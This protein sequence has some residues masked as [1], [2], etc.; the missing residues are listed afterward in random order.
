MR[1]PGTLLRRPSPALV[2]AAL[3]LL[4]ALSGSGYAAIVLPKTSVGTIQLRPG[5]VTSPKVRDATLRLSDL[6]PAT[7]LALK[8]DPG[9][10]GAAGVSG[11]VIVGTSSTFDSSKSKTIVVR[12]PTGK[13]L[14]GGGAGAW[15][16][17]MVFVPDGVALT[18]NHP[19]DE[20]GWL[21]A[22]HEVVPTEQDWSLRANAVCAAVG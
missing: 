20:T 16:R 2:V 9:A 22:A 7:R 5:S 15:G 4:V 6:S 10:P 3:A 21:A 12:C 8:G 19:Y 13:K 11:L 17:A 1:R 18:A 14:V